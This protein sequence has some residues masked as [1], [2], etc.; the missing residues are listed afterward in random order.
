M[1]TTKVKIAYLEYVGNGSDKWYAAADMS[2][3]PG[4]PLGGA[5]AITAHGPRG[6]VQ[7]VKFLAAHEAT[8]KVIEKQRKGYRVAKFT[9]RSIID[10]LAEKMRDRLVSSGRTITAVRLETDGEGIVYLLF[11][12]DDAAP[13]SPAAPAKPRDTTWAEDW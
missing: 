5:A 7:A 12:D 1:A 11:V 6:R 2:A 3:V 9:D 13:A 10:V 8:A 4:F